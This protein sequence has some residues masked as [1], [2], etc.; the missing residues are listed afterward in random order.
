MEERKDSDNIVFDKNVP[1]VA[2]EED[3][4]DDDEFELDLDDFDEEDINP[5]GDWKDD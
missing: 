3:I 1:T 2:G 4:D 5:N